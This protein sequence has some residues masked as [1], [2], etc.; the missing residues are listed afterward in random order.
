MFITLLQEFVQSASAAIAQHLELEVAFSDGTMRPNKKYG[1][2]TLDRDRIEGDRMVPYQWTPYELHYTILVILC[3]EKAPQDQLNARVAAE[4]VGLRVKLH[5]CSKVIEFTSPAIAIKPCYPGTDIE[6]TAMRQQA[7]PPHLF[8][9]DLLAQLVIPLLI[10]CDEH[11]D[12][13]EV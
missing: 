4:T 10:R 9:C 11:G 13:L 7:A 2:I 1:I 6:V 8:E 5:G 12:F 3:L